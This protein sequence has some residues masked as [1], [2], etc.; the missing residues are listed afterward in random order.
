[1]TAIH[2]RFRTGL[3]ASMEP[4][5]FRWGNCDEVPGLLLPVTPQW[6]PTYSGG[7]TFPPRIHRPGAPEASME[8]H[9]FRWGN[10]PTSTATGAT[11][12]K[13]QWSPTYSGGETATSSTRAPPCA[14]CLNGAPPIQVGK[15]VGDELRPAPMADASMEPHLFRWGNKEV[16]AHDATLYR[17][18]WSPTYSGGETSCR[19]GRRGQGVQASM[20]PHLFRWG[21]VLQTS[22]SEDTDVPQWSPTYSGGET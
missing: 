3:Y 12:P 1:M 15:P 4:H 5:L 6:S 8:P 22:A 18:Q 2:V 16:E 21:N 17:P 7:E 13:P 10:A 14:A 11:H 20:E 9:L 19:Q